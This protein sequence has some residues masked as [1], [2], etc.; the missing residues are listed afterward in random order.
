MGHGA[1][2]CGARLEM[3]RLTRTVWT[4]TEMIA[5]H[6]R[7]T[8]EFL[9]GWYGTLS[10]VALSIEHVSDILKVSV[11]RLIPDHSKAL[12]VINEHI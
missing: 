9:F 5:L 11:P 10:T 8:S 7:G 4:W 2:S 6:S 3:K 1:L 12:Q